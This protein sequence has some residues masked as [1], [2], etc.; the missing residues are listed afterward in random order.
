MA[1][2]PR[3]PA[4][5]LDPVTD[6]A[7]RVVSGEILANRWVRLACQRHL[8]DLSRPD[9]YWDLSAALHHIG[10]FENV[11]SLAFAEEPHLRPF[12]LMPHWKFIQGSLFGWKR[13]KPDGSPGPR[14]FWYFYGEGGKGMAKTPM[15]AGTGL[16]MATADGEPEAQ[17]FFAASSKDQ[18]RIAFDFAVTLRDNSSQLSLRLAKSGVNPCVQ[19]TYAWPQK[20]SERRLIGSWLKP[21]ASGY[22]QSGPRPHFVAFDEIHELERTAV[23]DIMRKAMGKNRSQ[24]LAY[25]I[26]NSGVDRTS[27]CYQH[28]VQAQKMLDGTIPNDSLFAYICGLDE[29]TGNPE[30]CICGKSSTWDRRITCPGCGDLPS[31]IDGTPQDTMEYLLAHEEI[32]VKA[33]P[34]IGE[35]PSYEYVRQQIKDAIGLPSQRNL[36]LRLH[37]CI[38]TDAISVWIPDET[39]MLGAQDRALADRIDH[40][41]FGVI[42]RLEADLITR[43]CYGG[44]DLARSNDWS[45]LVLLFPDDDSSPD[46]N[47]QV[48]SILEWFW[49]DEETYKERR[50]KNPLIEV[51]R[52]EGHLFVT[53]GGGGTTFDPSAIQSFLVDSIIPRYR[54]EGIAYDRTFAHQL[55]LNLT[56]E[57]MTMVEWAPTFW[58]MGAPVSEL[59]RRAKARLF[60]HRGHPVMREHMRN[61]AIETDAG[62]LKRINKDR[63]VEKVDGAVAL[64]YAQGWCM[65]ANTGAQKSVYERRGAVVIDDVHL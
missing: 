3:T 42:T 63:S 22:I 53:T 64:A 59:E 34:G 49:I 32:W 7:T 65:R 1:R 60:R 11:L 61:V 37:F 18:A 30:D 51:W 50:K 57:G 38:W 21:I 16:Y 8:S 36:V 5:E 54:I 27:I 46:P 58:W 62:G 15:A 9:L 20:D 10:F 45:S 14:R 39:W 6:Y 48:Y 29:G 52:R 31:D 24:P 26:T 13:R 40:P 35:V 28:R 25:E 47:N 55:V 17:C 33:N 12:L 41:R 44:I 4:P 23:L 19:M 2:K 56:G 43:R